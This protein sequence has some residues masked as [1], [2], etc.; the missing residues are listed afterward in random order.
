MQCDLTCADADGAGLQTAVHQH[1]FLSGPDLLHGG[2]DMREE[3]LTLRGQLN[4]AAGP[5]EKPASE[6]IFQIFNGSRHI[7][8]IAVENLGGL[9][10][11]AV[12]GYIIKNAVRIKT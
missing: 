10:E 12:L 5:D 2:A 11:T 4:A 8:L 6:G 9:G 7:G 3:F 1:G